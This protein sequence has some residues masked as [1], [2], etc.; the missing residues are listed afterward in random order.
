MTAA[1]DDIVAR[2]MIIGIFLIVVHSVKTVAFH[3]G[4]NSVS[5]DGKRLPRNGTRCHPQRQQPSR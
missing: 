4:H 5:V 2:N 3:A 1:C